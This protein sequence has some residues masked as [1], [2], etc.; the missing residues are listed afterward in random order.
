MGL[1]PIVST[2]ENVM[3]V[4]IG[5]SE[6]WGGKYD[7]FSEKPQWEKI[8]MSVP[9]SER[10]NPDPTCCTEYRGAWRLYNKLSWY[11]PE[12]QAEFILGRSLALGELVVV[13]FDVK[14][15]AV[16]DVKNESGKTD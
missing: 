14:I 15:V 5:R 16:V 4:W 13:E 10:K 6:A 3:K 7:L 11:L 8:A 2:G 9:M 1:I 12:D